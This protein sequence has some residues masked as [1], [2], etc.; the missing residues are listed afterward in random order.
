MYGLPVYVNYKQYGSRTR[1]LGINRS[2]CVP[3][4]FA[5]MGVMTVRADEAIFIFKDES[6]KLKRNA[7]VL[8][9]GSGR[10]FDSP[11]S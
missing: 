4:L 1:V 5:G 11:H 9:A 3:P 8:F 7:A 10:F 2:D 6:G